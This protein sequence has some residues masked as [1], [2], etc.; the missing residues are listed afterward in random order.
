MKVSKGALLVLM[1]AGA[2]P[3]SAQND[4]AGARD[5]YGRAIEAVSDT[6]RLYSRCIS[7]SGGHNSC[8][9]EFKR[10]EKAQ[11]A[12]DEAVTQIGFRCR[13]ERQG[14]FGDPE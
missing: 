4:C 3:A 14:K 5:D 6:L 12:F 11:Q 1:L 8:A 7:T 10:L 13:V 2:V 9:L